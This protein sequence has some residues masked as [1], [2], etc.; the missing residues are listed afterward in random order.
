MVS[1]NMQPTS[2]GC[3]RVCFSV[4]EASVLRL[5]E[6]FFHRYKFVYTC[7]F[8]L[9]FVYTYLYFLIL[10]WYYLA[11]L[12]LLYLFFYVMKAKKKKTITK[13]WAD[14]ESSGQ[15]CSW[16]WFLPVSLPVTRT[17]SFPWE[18]EGGVYIRWSTF[19]TAAYSANFLITI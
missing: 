2:L 18:E 16:V 11:S 3:L 13:S 12:H 4:S 5:Q 17:C 10:F 14:W 15:A 19:W 1:K 6:V 9:Y 7:V 8:H